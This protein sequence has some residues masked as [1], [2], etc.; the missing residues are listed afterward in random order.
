MERE[1]SERE[2]RRE[3][4]RENDVNT[5]YTHN[6]LSFTHGNRFWKDFIDVEVK[7]SWLV[8]T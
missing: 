1:T 6:A 4:E 2:R 7:T 5:I 3:S 8:V